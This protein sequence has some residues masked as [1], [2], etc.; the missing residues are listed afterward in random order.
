MVSPLDCKQGAEA[1]GLGSL[2]HPRSRHG[3][4]DVLLLYKCGKMCCITFL[5]IKVETTNEKVG[6]SM[7]SI[8]FHNT[9]IRAQFN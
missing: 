1:I 8:L 9:L 5:L 3:N 4:S 6:A 7:K 2:R